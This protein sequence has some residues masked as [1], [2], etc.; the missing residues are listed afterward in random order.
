MRVL[1]LGAGGML[2]HKLMQRL[3]GDFEVTGTL[4]GD[5]EPYRNAK[6]LAGA[7]LRL[8]VSADEISSVAAALDE[9]RPDAVLNCIG[10]VKQRAA[11]KDP[12]TAIGLNALFPH[13]LA[14]LCGGRGARLIHFSTDCVFSGRGG[15]YAEDAVS[16]AQD[17]YGRTKFLGELDRPGCLTLRTSIIGREI[18]G[19][20]SLV[21]WFLS[22]RGGRVKG[23]ANAL[24]TGYTTIAMAGLVAEL[25]GRF[26][27]LEGVWNLASDPISKFDLLRI[28]N[29]VYKLGITIDRDETFF[30]DRR[31]DGSAFRKR[32]GHVPVP[33]EQMIVEM[34]ADPTDYSR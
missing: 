16:D 11:A 13:K 22:Q 9:T 14:E 8:G 10:V 6:P 29:R 18:A 1:V 7:R 24:Y 32:T 19:R 4:R 31:L 34:H 33:W 20:Q 2:G 23:F 27:S 12:V 30:C 5:G 21:E 28:V 25:V 15:P 3:A 26:P 17:L